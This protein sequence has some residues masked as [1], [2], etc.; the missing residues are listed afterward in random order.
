MKTLRVVAIVAAFSLTF[1]GVAQAQTR[2]SPP[3]AGG[4]YSENAYAPSLAKVSL[5]VSG[6]GKEIIGGGITSG[7]HCVA[8]QTIVNEG[9]PAGTD[10]EILFPESFPIAASGSFHFAGTVTLQTAQ[11]NGTTPVS[12]DISF[13]G[14]FV[15][16]VIVAHKTTAV[17]GT[18]SSP[19]LCAPNTPTR[20]MLQWDVRD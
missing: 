3:F 2:K 19:S 18:F 11:T 12:G 7:A 20:V 1:A 8:S 4:F 9:V 6:N 16:G 17:I 15:K 5:F 13:I 14:H 10:V